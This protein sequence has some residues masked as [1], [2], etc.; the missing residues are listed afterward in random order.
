M[1]ST[2]V[3]M[4]HCDSVVKASPVVVC[5]AAERATLDFLRTSYQTSRTKP[6]HDLFAACDLL[7]CDRHV[8]TTTYAEAILRT[9]P[10]TLGRRAIILRPGDVVVTFDE[11]WLLALLRACG[12]GNRD[13]IAFLTNSRV[14][15]RYRPN[16]L[17]LMSGL[18]KLLRSSQLQSV[19]VTSDTF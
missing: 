10:Q 14:K 16:L 1:G 5:P 19:S 3:R 11:S 2:Q 18:A 8:A 4:I 15:L 7:T 17:Y 12:T 9:L 6:R 13:N